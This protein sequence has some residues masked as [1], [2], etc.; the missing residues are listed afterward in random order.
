MEQILGSSGS[1]ELRIKAIYYIAKVKLKQKDFYEAYYTL[2]RLPEK[3][4]NPKIQMFTK[5]VEGVI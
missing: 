3:I 4:D 5:L 1:D 2:T